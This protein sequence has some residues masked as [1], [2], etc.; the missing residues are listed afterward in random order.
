MGRKRE[1]QSPVAEDDGRICGP[2]PEET[3]R[4]NSSQKGEEM[5]GFTTI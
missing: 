5:G 2:K 1:A 4:W 3:S